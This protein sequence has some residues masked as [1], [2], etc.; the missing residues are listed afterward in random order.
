MTSEQ[1]ARSRF[2]RAF[3]LSS[4]ATLAVTA[5]IFSIASQSRYE[6]NNEYDDDDSFSPN[7]RRFL[8]D[9]DAIPDSN[10]TDT[11]DSI[12]LPWWAYVLTPFVAG[13]VGYGTNKLALWMTFYPI[14]FVGYEFMRFK[15]QPF[16]LFGWQGIIPT[17]A[18]KMAGMSCDIMT[19]KLFNVKDIFQRIDRK[20]AGEH[21]RPGFGTAISK[22]IDELS[23][24][25]ILGRDT[26]WKATEAAIKRKVSKW[27]MAELPGFV[28]G[29]MQDMIDNLDDCYDLRHMVVTEMVLHPE[30]VSQLFLEVG[31]T[32]LVFIEHSGFYFG[33]IFGLF[34]SLLMYYVD[35]SWTLPVAGA[36][37]G[38]LT[39][40]LALK[41]IFSPIDPVYLFGG[42]VKLQ[43]LFL[44][45]QEQA[46]ADFATKVVETVLHSKNIWHYLLT[47]PKHEGFEAILRSH[48][49][50]FTDRLIG[51]TRPLVE[52]YMG[53]EE[54][55]RMKTKV[56]DE[57]LA[58]IED[59][60]QYMHDYTDQALDLETEIRTKM[61]ALPSCEFE[62]VLHPAFEEDEVKLILVGA[63]LGA[64]AGGLQALLYFSF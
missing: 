63:V 31:K 6:S 45:R 8:A 43:G 44:K 40:W 30:M 46:S 48:T 39:N 49:D 53:S 36:L 47:G 42:R 28:E 16:G 57:T 24:E 5:T 22:I 19:T 51:Y 32:E 7:L 50:V 55:A 1:D 41:M 59:I 2:T 13:L 60:I 56:Q 33:F 29:F 23:D 61:Q 9:S 11:D 3:V 15:E 38:F 26:T 25:F 4:I 17:K 27:S 14:N 21:M 54:F 10:S 52:A 12:E 64:A 18:G 35:D 20:V 62:R 34:Q 37:V 58:Q